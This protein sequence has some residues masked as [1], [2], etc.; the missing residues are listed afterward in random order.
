MT[1]TIK[2]KS[3]SCVDEISLNDVELKSVLTY[4][5]Y[6]NLLDEDDQLEK[7][8][9]LEEFGTRFITNETWLEVYDANKLRLDIKSHDILNGLFFSPDQFEG[10]ET[11]ILNNT[12]I[13]ITACVAQ[14]QGGGFAII[15]IK[16]EKWISSTSDGFKNDFSF[17]PKHSVFLSIGSVSTYTWYV[18]D[19]TIIDL[20]GR[21]TCLDLYSCVKPQQKIENNLEKIGFIRTKTKPDTDNKSF[22]HYFYSSENDEIYLSINDDEHFVC[23]FTKIMNLIEFQS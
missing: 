17:I 2:N 22:Y 20:F 4:D 1:I 15:D 23:D 16:N 5:E 12:F 6:Q 8:K 10:I 19:L 11:E 3:P 21:I 13:A 7:W 9:V 18:L 14:G